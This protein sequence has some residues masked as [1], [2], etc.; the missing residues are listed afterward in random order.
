MKGK[1][2]PIKIPKKTSLALIPLLV[3]AS[4]AVIISVECVIVKATTIVTGG[5]ITTDTTWNI[6]GSPYII[7]GDVTVVN[8]V[9]LTIEPGV[10]VKFDGYYSLIV[11]G[12]I[13]AI[14]TEGNRITI[15]SNKGVPAPKDWVQIEIYGGAHAEIKYCDISYA[16]D[17]LYFW[18]SSNNLVSNCSFTSN[19][20]SGIYLYTSSDNN[21]I[22][23]NYVSGSNFGI[24]LWSSSNNNISNN[25]LSN[26]GNGIHLW[27]SSNIHIIGNNFTNDGVILEGD[28]LQHFNSHTIPD[29]NIVN[30]KPLYYYKNINGIDINGI[31]VGQII[32]ANC[33]SFNLKNLEIE[34]ADAA[35][36][37]AFSSNIQIINNHI[38]KNKAHGIFLAYLADNNN[39]TNNHVIDNKG[40]SINL[41]LSSN[42]NIINNNF[43]S[44]NL[45]GMYVVASSNNHIT[46]NIFFNN[47]LNGLRLGGASNN[48]ITKNLFHS[49]T[50]GGVDLTSSDY[51]QITANNVSNNNIGIKIK[52]SSNNQIFHNNI[53]D[54]SNQA[55]DDTSSNIWNDAYP[56]GGNFWSDWSPTCNDLYNGT[57]TPQTTGSPD[58]ICDEQYDIDGDSS[59]FYPLKYPFLPLPDIEPPT[60][61][62]VIAVPDPQDVYDYVNISATVI[63]DEQLG[64]VWINITDPNGVTLEND[65]MIYDNTNDRYYYNISYILLGTYQFTIFA[66]DTNNNWNSMSGSF[67]I[68]DA[69]PPLISD[70]VSDPDLQ[71]IL[72]NINVSAEIIDNFELFDVW[73][74]ITHPNGT[75]INTTMNEST[76]DVFY[77]NQSYDTLGTYNYKIWANDTS[78]NWNF[79]SGS[80]YIQDTQR[81]SAIAEIS[82]PYWKNTPTLEITW[83]ASDNFNLSNITLLYRYSA[84]NAIWDSWA[85]YSYN[86]SI[87]GTF[88]SGSFQFIAPADG[89]Y[90]FFVNASD[91]ENNWEPNATTPEA[92]TAI[93]TSPPSSNTNPISIYWINSLPLVLGASALDSLSGINY[94]TLWFRYSANN[95]SW[96]PWVIFGTD[97]IEPWSWNFN[98]PNGEGYYEFYST[99]TDNVDNAESKSQREALCAYDITSPIAY[100]GEDKTIKPNTLV[101]LDSMGS[102]DNFGV[103]SNYTWTIIKDLTVVTYLYDSNSSFKFDTLG[104]YTVTLTIKDTCGNTDDDT[105]TVNVVADFVD[106]DGPTI[107]PLANPVTQ[108]VHNTVN[109]TADV[110][111]NVEVSGVWVQILDSTSNELENVSMNRIGLS[112]NYWYE[113]SY[114]SVGT[115]T[116][117]IWANDTSGIWASESGSFVVEDSTSPTARAGEDQSIDVNDTVYFDGSGSTDNVV[118]INYTWNI[119]RNGALITTLYGINPSYRFEEAGN[120]TVTLITRDAAGYTDSDTMAVTVVAEP[121]Q[122]DKDEKEEQ[123]FLWLI[124]LIVIIIVVIIVIILL[125]RKKAEPVESESETSEQEK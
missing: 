107:I 95:I 98:F 34:N 47:N 13:Y 121:P 31:P 89:Y 55:T 46:K 87:S 7:T 62:G 53:L 111:D 113:R 70:V 56:S 64:D 48:V 118:I 30:G 104:T 14:G 110:T 57:I 67:S 96:N 51:N 85:E 6:S 24:H 28:L 25:I 93:D 77:I 88:A 40:N 44:N 27:K 26:N 19:F 5:S 123:D 35:I 91:M 18:S 72:R 22:T 90:E 82:S 109:I 29:N 66:Y 117:T 100:A 1:V 112:E 41:F 9:N 76:G 63:D 2:I 84:D 15:T 3:L 119:T 103:I 59:D 124:L 23:N 33:N 37:L 20:G 38:S 114:S 71:E 17:G 116:Y 39:I 75:S 42:N 8:G 65:T 79:D 83:T 61:D 45:D 68:E 4:F 60:I 122:E 50:M 21:I 86:N 36:E 73:L 49:N 10:E 125:K 11:H 115:F 16:W 74:N 92:I 32:L 102:S 54:N 99:G 120:Y 81:P 108:E 80:F 106:Q 69:T 97:T 58:G 52:S 12:S 101:Y 94:M 43:S 78:N 105:I